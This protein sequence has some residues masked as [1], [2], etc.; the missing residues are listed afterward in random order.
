[1]WL[2]MIDNNEYDWQGHAGEGVK[3]DKKNNWQ[4]WLRL[5]KMIMI[6]YAWLWLI[7]IDN[8]NNDDLGITKYLP[9]LN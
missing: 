6:S 3:E 9:A 8:G 7:M 4:W 5:M 1:M 2:I